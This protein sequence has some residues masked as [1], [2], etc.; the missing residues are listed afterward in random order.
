[1]AAWGRR[2]TL[3]WDLVL[4]M[5]HSFRNGRPP[6]RFGWWLNFDFFGG[7]TKC[8]QLGPGLTLL[9]LDNVI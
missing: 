5:R 7:V 1:M 8:R 6:H 9:W 4:K 2:P 3:S